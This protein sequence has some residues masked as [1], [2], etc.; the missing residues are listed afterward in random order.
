MLVANLAPPH[1]PA[2]TAML[3]KNLHPF[4]TSY[5]SR[6][7]R[8][9]QCWLQITL[10]FISRTIGDINSWV[11]FFSKSKSLIN[12]TTEGCAFSSNITV[13]NSLNNRVDITNGVFTD[14]KILN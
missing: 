13:F 2:S 3:E 10:P 14:L 9:Q 8:A 5:S 4:K 7:Q 12:N 6:P 1:P 11:G